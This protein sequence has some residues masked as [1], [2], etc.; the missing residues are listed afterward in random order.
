MAEAVPSRYRLAWWPFLGVAAFR[1]QGFQARDALIG[2]LF[3]KSIKL[4]S[5][6]E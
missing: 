1:P 3:N 2:V 4:L 6:A 5:L